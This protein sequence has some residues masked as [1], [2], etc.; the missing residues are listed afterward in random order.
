[1]GRPSPA[2]LLRQLH[3]LRSGVQGLK[4]AVPELARYDYWHGFLAAPRHNVVTARC[5]YKGS[6]PGTARHSFA[7][8]VY[9]KDIAGPLNSAQVRLG[10]KWAAEEC[11]VPDMCDKCFVKATTTRTAEKGAPS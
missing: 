3:V 7:G 8:Q 5:E 1:V 10:V 11:N 2:I 4:S 9:S 6:R